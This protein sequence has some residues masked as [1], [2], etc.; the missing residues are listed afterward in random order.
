MNFIIATT[1]RG[2]ARE[3][4]DL[5]GEKHNLKTLEDINFKENIIESGSTFAENACIKAEAVRSWIRDGYDY[6]LADDSGLMIDALNGDPGVHSAQWLGA[7]TP[8]DV[9]N[10]RILEM[11]RGITEERRKARFV[12]VIACA[13]QTGSI[14]TVEG[15]LEGRI[16]FKSV[17]DNGFGYDPIFFVPDVNQTLAQLNSLEKTRISHRGQALCHMCNLLGVDLL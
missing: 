12:C 1:N 7:N 17:G 5:L 16:A 11:L 13:K 10:Q 9:K 4:Q 14:K 15:V 8:Y 2:K 6:I 3:I